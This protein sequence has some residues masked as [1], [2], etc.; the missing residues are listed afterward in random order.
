MAQ[1]RFAQGT[2]EKEGLITSPGMG[3]LLRTI[4]MNPGK[5]G[6][7]LIVSESG[8]AVGRLILDPFSQLLY[9]TKAEE[10]SAVEDLVKQGLPVDEAID[11]L[12]LIKEKQRKKAS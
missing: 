10:F 9:S 5:Y 8:Y 3:G 1:G 4:K 11:R 7:I 12:L 2:F 6:E